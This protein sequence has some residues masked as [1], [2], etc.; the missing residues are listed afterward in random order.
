MRSQAGVC[1]LEKITCVV[2]DECHRAVGKNDAVA[3]I[4]KLRTERCKFRVLGLSA[5]PG[6]KREAIQVKSCTFSL[7]TSVMLLWYMTEISM[8]CIQTARAVLTYL[9]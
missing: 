2:V 5:T 8:A 6:S 3:A 7:A 4:E 1:P 9:M